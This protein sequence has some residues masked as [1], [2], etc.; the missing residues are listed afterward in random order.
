MGAQK[1]C[2]HVS[3][4]GSLFFFNERNAPANSTTNCFTCPCEPQCAYSAKKLYIDSKI[5]PSSWPCSV[6]LQSEIANN[7]PEGSTKDIEDTMLIDGFTSESERLAL[8]ERCLRNEER[9]M[10]GRCVFKIPDNDV[11][12]N[13]VV[14]MEF[15]DGSTATLT[16]IAFTKDVCAR[17]TKV[18][19]T[20]GELEWDNTRYPNQ[21]VHYDFVTKQTTMI[22]C[23]INED[24]ELKKSERANKNIKLSGHSGTDFWLMNRFVEACLTR[25]QSLVLTDL[26]DS[27]RSHLIVFAAEHSRRIKQVVNIDEFCRE[28]NIQL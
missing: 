18:Y 15:D 13:Q 7:I 4:F 1:K 19:G 2:A 10:Y 28:N 11:C 3:S 26:E 25:N 24:E 14:N 23:T 20:L 8:L 9:T 16:M 22:D 6:V 17:K 12:D 21:I 27:M 5:D